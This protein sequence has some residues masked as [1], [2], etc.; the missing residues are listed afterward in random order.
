MRNIFAT[1]FKE[2]RKKMNISQEEIAERLNVTPQAI[3]KWECDKSYPDIETLIEISEILKISLD[4]LIKGDISGSITT[5]ENLPD[6]DTIRVILCKG[7]K[8]INE[9]SDITTFKVS[10]NEKS[11]K[12]EIWGNAKIEGD[13]VGNI[14]AG[15]DVS[16]NNV[17]G[18]ITAGA[19][20]ECNN[21]IGTIT[22]GYSIECN[23]VEGPVMSAGKLDANNLVGPVT[24][25]SFINCE[26]ID[27]DI[28]ECQG[29]IRC[30]K[31]NGN[32]EECKKIVY[33]GE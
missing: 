15:A 29:D 6:D 7:R 30:T 10:I 17:D 24:S 11:D 8:T 12:I 1:Q 2:Y 5:V 21:V 9:T 31:I 20:V 26:K 18:N 14:T 19:A 4:N 13:V 27:G 33:I 32:I 23:N 16:C 22:A 25:G 28:K 3:S